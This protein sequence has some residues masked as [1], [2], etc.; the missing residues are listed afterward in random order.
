MSTTLEPRKIVSLEEGGAV[1]DMEV[2]LEV[3]LDDRVFAL[4]VPADLDVE[5]VEMKLVDGE[6]TLEPVP[7]D[8]VVSLKSDIKDALKAWD[9]EFHFED[10]EAFLRGDPDEAFFADCETVEVD[11][12]EGESE[13][14]DDKARQQFSDILKHSIIIQVNVVSY[15]PST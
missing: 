10:G 1:V 3:E 9:V 13:D 7:A 11:T 15:K 6:D 14:H 5:L 12:D 4:L 8:T 2:Y